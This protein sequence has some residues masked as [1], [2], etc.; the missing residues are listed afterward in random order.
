MKRRTFLQRFGSLLAVLGLTEAEWFSLGNRYQQALAQPS[1]RK[2]ALIIGINQY[3][4]SQ[5]LNGC[6]TDVELQK[7]L[8]IHRFGFQPSDILALTDE[9]AS[10]E[11]IESAFVEHLVKQ[12]KLGDIVLFH[13]SGYGSRVRLGTSLEAVQNA[14]VTADSAENKSQ[15]TK[16]V[17]YL[18]EETLMLML[19]SLPTERATAVLDTSYYTP[20]TFLPTGLRIR[21]RQM[22]TEAIVAAAELDLQKQL[23]EKAAT[24]L[25]AVVLSATTDPNQVAQEVQLSGFSAGLF[26]YA[27][28]QYLWEATPATTIPISISRVGSVMQQFGSTQQPSLL[29]GKKNQQRV[30]L[31]EA[32]VPPF[33]QSAEGV[34]TAVEDEGKT[35]HLWLAGLPVQVLEYYGANSRLT[36]VSQEGATAQLVLRSRNGLTAKAQLASGSENK[37]IPQMGQLVQETVRVLPRNINLTVA[38]DGGLERIERVDAT[39]AFATVEHVSSVVAGEQP[40]DYVFGELPDGKTKDL[41]ASTALIV[42]PSRYGLFSL[43]SELIPSTIGEAGEAVKVAV[44]RLKPTLQ[45]LLAA[46]LWRLTDNEGSSCLSVKA[47]LEI[48]NGIT[49]RVVMQR[50]T[51]R[52]LGAETVSKKQVNT[53]PGRIPIVPIGSKIHYRIQNMGT[54]PVYLMLLGLNSAKNA[55]ALYPWQKETESE[56]GTNNASLEDIVIAPGET[57]TLPQSTTGFEWVIQGPAFFSENQLIFSTSPFTQTRNALETTKHPRADRQRIQPLLNPLEVANALLQDLH[58]VSPVKAEMNI[59]TAESYVLDVN[60]WASLAFMYQVI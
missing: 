11:F 16:I 37:I 40:A 3:Q 42:S 53:E 36:L 4:Q 13:F 47:T 33:T 9:Q 32:F 2:L 20:T 25:S 39:S 41:I 52:T 56:D 22:T 35:I 18:L 49:P 12:A 31:S 19:R 10:R 8:L 50:E 27:L 29:M 43:G 46:K 38:L 51:M 54:Q 58:N 30:T 14:L 26:T 48:V 6:L 17:N 45:T 24:E 21:S 5:I 59:S 55:I 1:P 23:R 44:Q 28:T 34:V 57:L 60:N 15:A 7:E